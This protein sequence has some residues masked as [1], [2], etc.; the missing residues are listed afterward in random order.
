ML[1]HKIPETTLRL[2]TSLIVISSWREGCWAE[3]RLWSGRDLSLHAACSRLLGLLWPAGQS[4]LLSSHETLDPQKRKVRRTPCCLKLLVLTRLTQQT[5][6]FTSWDTALVFILSVLQP[7]AHEG[8]F[9]QIPS[10]VCIIQS[11]WEGVKKEHLG[12]AWSGYSLLHAIPELSERIGFERLLDSLALFA[13][14]I[15]HH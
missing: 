7:D 13:R 10:I 3:E 11:S 14:T 9:S 2:C 8:L 15:N 1:L 4:T 5:L 6:I 12:S